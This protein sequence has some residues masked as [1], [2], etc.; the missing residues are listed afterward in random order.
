MAR[1][2]PVDISAF[3]E[4][5]QVESAQRDMWKDESTQ[6]M[7][8]RL[9]SEGLDRVLIEIVQSNEWAPFGPTDYARLKWSQ[10]DFD[11]GM[12]RAF[13][14]KG[15]GKRDWNIPILPGLRV[16]LKTILKRHKQAGFGAPNDFVYLDKEW[17]K[18]NPGWVSTTLGRCRKA[19][20]IKEVTYS[21]RHR[22]ITQVAEKTDRDTASKFAGHASI[23]TTEKHYL[24]ANED[25]LKNKIKKAYDD[26]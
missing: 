18:I 15:K 12:I 17:K 14:L 8:D 1:V 19:L 2:I 11:A 3:I 20:G 6:K 13:R 22:I 26:E 24:I 16:I 7:I 9:E 5:L 21:S 25:D 10:I 23:R 4:T